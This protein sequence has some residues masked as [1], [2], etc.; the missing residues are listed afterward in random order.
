[1]GHMYSSLDNVKVLRSTTEMG[2]NV[3][4]REYDKYVNKH[5][6]K[7]LLESPRGKK[8]IDRIILKWISEK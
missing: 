3:T 6:H 5:I 2:G 1:M 4:S 7:N 8:S